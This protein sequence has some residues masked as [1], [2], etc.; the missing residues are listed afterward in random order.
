MGSQKNTITIN[1]KVY[2]A[3][4]GMVISDIARTKIIKPAV[5][6]ASPLQKSSKPKP[7][8][9]KIPITKKKPSHPQAHRH[10]PRVAT[11]L[12]TKNEHAKTL[13]RN[14]VLK[15]NS[16]K[17][18][19]QTVAVSG[20]AK[21][22][23]HTMVHSKTPERTLRASKIT[24]SN[25]V[26]RFDTKVH[27]TVTHTTKA[28]PVKTPPRDNS[29]A[30]KTQFIS[31]QAPPI[32]VPIAPSH[33][34]MFEASL[35]NATNHRPTKIGISSSHRRKKS[36][37]AKQVGAIMATVFVLGCFYTYSN[38]P[39]I[40]LKMKAGQT[41]FTANVP[42]YKPTGFSL[43]RAIQSK[44]GSVIISYNSRIDDRAFSITQE[45]TNLSN[46]TISSLFLNEIT[47]NYSAE[48]TP[49]KTVYI[50][51]DSNAAW[52]KDGILYNIQGNAQLSRSQLLNLAS[53]L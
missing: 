34:A 47:N 36:T 15:P 45:K 50:Y 13:M 28:I 14:L 49:D 7:A 12:H 21:Q 37:R 33:K 16:N 25:L 6:A 53:S 4:T 19:G 8:A 39:S 29:S 35:E 9:K 27:A 11:Q 10:T 5:V 40:S 44:P 32:T 52:V 30:G 51:D 42:S 43:N 1:G 26:S 20:L 46:E 17:K 3:D 48:A 41:G 18:S 31:K 2:D 38:I 23:K 22:P 24:K